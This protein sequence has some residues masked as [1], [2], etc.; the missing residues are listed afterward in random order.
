VNAANR[1]RNQRGRIE[2][3]HPGPD[4]FGRKAEGWNRFGDHNLVERHFAEQCF[5]RADEEAV[6]SRGVDARRTVRSAGFGG[7]C[8][9]AACADEIV[10]NDRTAI[11]D[12]TAAALTVYL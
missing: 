5:R 10:E 2:Y 11:L 6:R 4:R 1:F 8:E 3:D 12:V 7:T 9:R